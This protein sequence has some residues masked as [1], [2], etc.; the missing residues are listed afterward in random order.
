M[1]SKLSE[2][3]WQALLIVFRLLVADWLEEKCYYRK[4]IAGHDTTPELIEGDVFKIFIQYP[5][6]TAYDK[7]DATVTRDTLPLS[8]PSLSQVCPR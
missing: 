8:V 4:L 6:T 5:D 3:A 7:K 1:D 2:Q